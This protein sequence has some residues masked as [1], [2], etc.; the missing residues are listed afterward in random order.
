MFHSACLLLIVN[1]NCDT[2]HSFEDSCI[3]VRLTVLTP[4]LAEADNISSVVH[5]TGPPGIP[6]WN[7]NL[8]VLDQVVHKLFEPSAKLEMFEGL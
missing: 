2:G 8:S 6:H 3:N 1:K 5:T 7:Y 4:E